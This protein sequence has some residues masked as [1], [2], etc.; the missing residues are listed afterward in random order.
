[1]TNKA[2]KIK[3]DQRANYWLAEANVALENGKVAR[4]AAC[5]KKAQYW[6]DRLNKLE[7]Q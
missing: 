1:M 7:D 5:E 6:L 2:A 3:A 4:A